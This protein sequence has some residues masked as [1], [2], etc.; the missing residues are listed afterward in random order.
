[1]AT[2]IR[3]LICVLLVSS[4]DFSEIW[5]KRDWYPVVCPGGNIVAAKATI[6][7]RN[8]CF[9]PT[10]RTPYTSTGLNITQIHATK[11]VE[12][13]DTI[14]GID[15][16]QD[17]PRDPTAG[18]RSLDEW[19][20]DMADIPGAWRIYYPIVLKDTVGLLPY[21]G[22]RPSVIFCDISGSV[23]GP[24]NDESGKGAFLLDAGEAVTIE[25]EDS[26][27]HNRRICMIMLSGKTYSNIRVV[28]LGR[29][30][31]SKDYVL[32]ELGGVVQMRAAMF[33]G[34]AFVESFR[35]P[36]LTEALERIKRR[37]T[38]LDGRG[39]EVNPLTWEYQPL[40]NPG[41]PFRWMHGTDKW[42]YM[43]PCTAY[44]VLGPGLNI[45]HKPMIF[46]K[47]NDE[48]IYNIV[49]PAKMNKTIYTKPEKIEQETKKVLDAIFQSS[50]DPKRKFK[51]DNEAYLN[52]FYQEMLTLA[53]NGPDYYK[54]VMD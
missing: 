1:M 5:N 30:F 8:K 12:D 19:K 52:E 33:V 7:H 18:D 13:I 39:N 23:V 37:I 15:G 48:D 17:E 42:K 25:D 9:I 31:Y 3:H 41:S 45:S 22:I 27:I 50:D 44:R 47:Y 49:D 51:M 4:T 24:E 38:V 2:Y 14:P 16:D 43:G 20:S 6:N 11:E 10:F 40:N 53:K 29:M 26:Y 34:Q 21:P 32:D 28:L 35:S 46:D 54:N 36:E